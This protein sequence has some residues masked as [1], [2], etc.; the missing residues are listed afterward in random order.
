MRDPKGFRDS[1]GQSGGGGWSAGEWVAR[2]LL[3][4]WERYPGMGD[5]IVYFV[6]ILMGLCILV[7]DNEDVAFVC[8]VRLIH[9]IIC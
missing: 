3:L 6:V 7:L 5:Y 2:W 4:L 1:C 9:E 8:L